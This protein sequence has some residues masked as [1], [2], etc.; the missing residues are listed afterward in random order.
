MRLE[1]GAVFA[2]YTI[3]RVLGH[4]G[5]GVVYSARHP[6]LER[7]VALKVLSDSIAGDERARSRFEREAAL[8]A[9]L[10]HPHI[11][12]IYDRADSEAEVPW[13]CMKYVDGGDIALRMAAERG[14]LPAAEAVRLLG[15]AARGLDFAHRFGIVHRDIKP[16]NILLDRSEFDGG[17]AVLTDFGIARAF[18]DTLTATG[19]A[20]TFA[21]A[22]PERF[23]ST[24]SD[25]RADIYSLGCTFFEIL[26]GLTPFQRP[27][28]AGVIAAHLST[29]PPRVTDLRPELPRGFDEVIACAMAKDPDHRYPTCAAMA[30]AAHRVLTDAYNAKRLPDRTPGADPMPAASNPAFPSPFTAPPRTSVSPISGPPISTAPPDTF[31]P[32]AAT[33]RLASD[34][35]PGNARTGRPHPDYDAPTTL[36]HSDIH[37][38]PAA[39]V[40][41]FI[42]PGVVSRSR[43]ARPYPTWREYAA[44]CAAFLVG[45]LAIASGM[46]MVNGLGMTFTEVNTGAQYTPWESLEIGDTAQG[47]DHYLVGLLILGIVV[48]S[49]V[50]VRRI[51]REIRMALAIGFALTGVWGIVFMTQLLDWLGAHSRPDHVS[52]GYRSIFVGHVALVLAGLI[53]VLALALGGKPPFSTRA[54]PDLRA[55]A[56]RS[57]ATLAGATLVTMSIYLI[58]APAVPDYAFPWQIGTA[59]ILTIVPIIA[60][61]CSPRGVFGAL[62]LGW[63]LGGVPIGVLIVEESSPWYLAVLSAI[64][65]LLVVLLVLAALRVRA[66]VHLRAR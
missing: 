44:R 47:A 42:P 62:T 65:L 37:A 40:P 53:A 9:R 32:P 18:D 8:V 49:T 63:A 60:S 29:P 24:P 26:T 19:I 41:E 45:L 43:S 64:Y 12:P 5:M 23:G 1:P 35:S 48:G 20:A 38:S 17:R 31:I 7:R 25:H 30:E 14:P 28:Q 55:V 66:A 22:A 56:I 52:T 46:A 13:I 36:R 6:R 27:D 50:W 59:A 39:P 16:A 58:F 21:Y 3:E 51:P 61:A 10:E 34:P 33:T 15:E 54:R 2:G 57:A 11:V 4:G